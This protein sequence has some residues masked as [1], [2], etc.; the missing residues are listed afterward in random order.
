[1]KDRY[2]LRNYCID[3]I[4]FALLKEINLQDICDWSNFMYENEIFAM[5][6]IYTYLDNKLKQ[7]L[8]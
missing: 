1:M 3:Y 6:D 7:R 5:K 8:S 2:L 4:P